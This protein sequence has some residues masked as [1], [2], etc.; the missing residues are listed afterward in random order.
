MIDIRKS[1]AKGDFMFD[2]SGTI[3]GEIK[4]GAD[5]DKVH[6]LVRNN[7]TDSLELYLI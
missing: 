7:Q 1:G 3:V 6:A 2:V 5:Q 4:A